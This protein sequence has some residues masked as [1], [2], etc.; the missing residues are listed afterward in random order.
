MVTDEEFKSFLPKIAKNISYT[1]SLVENL[2]YWSKSQ[3]SGMAINIVNVD[4]YSIARLTIDAF[5]NMVAGK[6][7]KVSNQISPETMVLCDKHMLQAI[8]RNLIIKAIRFC[9]MGDKI[10]ISCN[11]EGDYATIQ[12]ADT[13]IGISNEN[14]SK[15]FASQIFTTNGTIY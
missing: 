15:L 1:S 7:L 5:A 2:L 9:R 8:L 10:N 4:I 6:E 14:L 13:G 3:L 12:V 11:I